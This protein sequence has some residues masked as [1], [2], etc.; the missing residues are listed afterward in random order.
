M[1]DPD[2][3]FAIGGWSTSEVAVFRIH[4]EPG[5][6]KHI[7]H[8]PAENLPQRQLQRLL[9]RNGACPIERAITP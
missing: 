4:N 5:E 3:F 2:L 7:P 8:F 6:T 9:F 1:A